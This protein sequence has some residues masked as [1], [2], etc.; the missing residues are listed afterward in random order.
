LAGKILEAMEIKRLS[1]GPK[2]HFFGFHDLKITNHNDD[3]ILALAV[4]IINR[5]PLPGELADVG[6]VNADGQYVRVGTT[7]AYNYPQGARMQWMSDTDFFIV[8]N[9]I[10][11]D[12]GADIYDTISGKHYKKLERSIHCLSADAK[13]GYSINYSRLFRLGVYGYIGIEDSSKNEIA[14]KKDGIFVQDIETGKSDLLISTNE[15]AN[16]KPLVSTDKGFHHYLTHLCLNP[17]SNRI[18]F[19]HRYRIQ[20]GGETTRLMSVD[21]D[22]KNL[23]CIA[24][25]SLS[26]F[27]WMDD[28]TIVIHGSLGGAVDRFRNSKLLANPI[29]GTSV[30]L[31]KNSLRGLINVIRKSNS[32]AKDYAFISV[33]DI[34]DS[35]G[36]PFGRGIIFTDGHPMF[37]PKHRNWM[38][39]DTYPIV[40]GIRELMLIDIKNNI[41]HD[42]GEFKMIYEENDLEFYKK[43]TQGVDEKILKLFSLKD[44]SFTRSGLHCDLHPRWNSKGDTVYFDSIHEGNR[45]LYAINVGNIING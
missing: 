31:A 9:Q 16:Y 44:Y 6:Y 17:S 36:V 43:Y 11:N 21:V 41:R 14:P 26:H 13:K 23:K 22:G 1:N 18:A 24:F 3:K 35:E 32:V 29:V 33:K 25:G 39:N 34:D 28:E 10:G 2:H 12:W 19:L 40:D 38:S 4:D 7:N 30:R 45:Q 42:L 20:D 15:V 5:P 8:N 27:D 37:N